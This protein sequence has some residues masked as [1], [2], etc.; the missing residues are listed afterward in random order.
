VPDDKLKV[1]QAGKINFSCLKSAVACKIQVITV[2]KMPA[3][4]SS[5]GIHEHR[6]TFEEKGAGVFGGF[7]PSGPLRRFVVAMLTCFGNFLH[8]SHNVVYIFFTNAPLSVPA[9]NSDRKVYY[10]KHAYAKQ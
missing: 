5:F 3:S 9:S 4:G 6:M 1:R 7:E 10:D 2:L 8:K